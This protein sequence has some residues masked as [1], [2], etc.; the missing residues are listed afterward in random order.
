M[1]PH[2]RSLIRLHCEEWGNLGPL[3]LDREIKPN[4]AGFRVR[5]T[6]FIAPAGVHGFTE[7]DGVYYW[8]DM[9]VWQQMDE[10]KAAMSRAVLKMRNMHR[11]RVLF[12]DT[13]GWYEPSFVMECAR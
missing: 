7:I 1:L 11:A 12:I 6:T 5:C 3:E 8:T 13:S 9:D 10:E 2:I 4:K